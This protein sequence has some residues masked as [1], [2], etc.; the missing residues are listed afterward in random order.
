MQIESVGL[1]GAFLIT[2]DIFYDDRGYF[3]EFF[4]QQKFQEKTGLSIHFVQD[5]IAQS[6]KGILRGL[7]FQTG[8][9]AQAK[10]VSVL[11]GKVLD[12]IVD[13]RKK[14]STFG[15]YFSV[16]LN[17]NQKQQLFIPRG[18]AHAY[19]CMQ[20]DTLFY[21]KVDNYY[22][23]SSESG[24]RFDDPDI[25]IDWPVDI[26]QVVLSEKDRNLAYLKDII[27]QL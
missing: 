17:D 22:H 3:Y 19:L 25:H 9:Y 13:L 16:I 18:F 1:Q 12:V 5:N 11:R 27:D 6:H 7:H 21:Y 4:N 10:L 24:I 8:D 23:Q 20:D 14:S 2:P 26:S 15:Q